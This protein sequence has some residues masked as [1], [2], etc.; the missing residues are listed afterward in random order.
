MIDGDT[1]VNW[2]DLY[3]GVAE[4]LAVRINRRPEGLRNLREVWN[5]WSLATVPAMSREV[6]LADRDDQAVRVL[7][8]LKKSPRVLSVQAEAADE[9]IAFLHAAVAQLP[10]NYRIYWE[11][12]ILVAR[13]DDVARQL[14]GLGPKLVVVLN[15]GDPG[16]AR[17]LGE[18]GHHVYVAFG[19]DVGSPAD[20]TRLPRPWRR[21]IGC[22]LE[23]MRVPG[24]DESGA[25]DSAMLESWV[26]EAR[27]LC[28]EA[29]QLEIGDHRIGQILSAARR[30]PGE[31]WPP[32]AVRDVIE[33]C[34]SRE[35]ERGFEIGLYNRRG[36]T[37]R[38]PTDGGEQ[39]R[40]LT[41]QYRAD[42]LAC[43]FTWE[44][45]KAVLERIAGS[46][47]RDAAR[48]DEGAEQRDWT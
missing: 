46:Y 11:S 23:A 27:R 30:F 13:S 14:V 35:L 9:A 20:V 18:D 6:I 10:L 25:I 8:W 16:V 19:S 7:R 42:A 26:N 41:A 5:E 48:E 39:E 47:E 44:R 34:R 2:L 33:R 43:A 12:R 29:G 38:L 40:A 17:A 37:V 22:E 36:V 45:T 24:S 32:E 21:T 1:L 31:A 4:W 28:A 15:G 3:P